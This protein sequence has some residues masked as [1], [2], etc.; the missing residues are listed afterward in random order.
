MRLPV[1]SQ[2]TQME[3]PLHPRLFSLAWVISLE[4]DLH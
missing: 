1:T 4:T 3:F 2:E